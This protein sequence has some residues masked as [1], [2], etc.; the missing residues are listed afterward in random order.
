MPSVF[1]AS[2][3]FHRET[4]AGHGQ[5]STEG[6]VVSTSMITRVRVGA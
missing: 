2:G 4:G 1:G 6:C 3:I 5:S